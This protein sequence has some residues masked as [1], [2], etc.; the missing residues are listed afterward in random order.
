MLFLYLFNI[1]MG[2]INKKEQ[3]KT[4]E[5]EGYINKEKLIKVYLWFITL[6]SIT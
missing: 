3:M 2:C 1:L 4:I 5:K 6:I